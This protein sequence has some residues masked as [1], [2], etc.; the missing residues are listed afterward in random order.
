MP[1]KQSEK[2]E[3]IKQPEL[4]TQI[5]PNRIRLKCQNKSQKE[6]ANLIL[7]NQIIIASGPAGVGKSYVAI[8]KAI[9]LLQSGDNNYQKLMIVRPAIEAGEKLGFMPGNLREKME[10]HMSATLDTIDK[11]I[12]KKER[13]R[14][15]EAEILVIQPLAFI[16][17]KSIDNTIVVVEEAQNMSPNQMKTLLTRIGNDSKFIISGDLDQS[18]KYLNVEDCGL[19]DAIHRH[20]NIPEIG[21]FKFNEEDIVRNPL[22]NKIL[23]NYTDYPTKKNKKEI[24]N[25]PNQEINKFRKFFKS[26]IGR[27]KW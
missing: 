18:D 11:I 1:K 17:G 8:A 7:S 26:C 13:I 3:F 10:P 21:F 15:E 19:Y 16:R 6:F 20:K 5:L 9:E 14:M 22:I 4:I 27:F 24:E 12:G 25:K 2:K 23:K